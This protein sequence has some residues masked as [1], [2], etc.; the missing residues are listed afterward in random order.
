V[1]LNHTAH[2]PAL[3]MYFAV[4]ALK[5]FTI[6]LILALLVG[7]PFF[8]VQSA[9]VLTDY[10]RGASVFQIQDPTLQNQ[11]SPVGMLYNF[12]LIYMFYQIDGP[13]IF[14]DAIVKTYQVVPPE[15]FINPLAL[16]INGPLYKA[17][18]QTL[19]F[20]VSIGIQLAAPAIVSILMTEMFLGIANRLAPQVQIAFL[21]L[22]LKSLIGLT[23]VWI[24]FFFLMKQFSTQT[25]KWLK[26]IDKLV[27]Y[28]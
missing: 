1:V 20:V 22:S 15:K 14:F 16:S 23:L 21:G 11:A 7:I 9:G 26:L 6:G 8:F 12:L 28:L 17:V 18:V 5:E 3:N 10:L 2:P 27:G 13:F 25:M 19:H 4:L 24:G